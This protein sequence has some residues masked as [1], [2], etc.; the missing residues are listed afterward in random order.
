VDY[1]ECVG[2][3]QH[4]KR[5]HGRLTVLKAASYR[6][7]ICNGRGPGGRIEVQHRAYAKTNAVKWKNY[8]HA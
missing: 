6:C 2:S 5:S 8:E 1:R 4:W 7:R 3:E